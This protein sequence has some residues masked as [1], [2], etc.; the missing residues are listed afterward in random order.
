[1]IG[2]PLD[3]H[4]PRAVRRE[5]VRRIPD[6]IVECVGDPGVPAKQTPDSELLIWCE[7]NGHIL[8]SK[9][10]RTMPQHFAD[11]IA[12]GRHVP[13]VFLTPGNWQTGDHVSELVVI[14]IGSFDGEYVDT[15]RYLPIT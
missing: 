14:G 15:I 13:G 10:R 4:I 8:V 7:T 12:S 6:L 11:H 5:L 2:Y 3:E 1:M 9:D